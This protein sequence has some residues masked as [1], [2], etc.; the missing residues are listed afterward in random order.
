M[1]ELKMIDSDNFW[2]S[3]KFFSKVFLVGG[4]LVIV[5][6]VF[7]YV[8]PLAATAG[9][10]TLSEFVGSG[11]CTPTENLHNKI[12]F[13]NTKLRNLSSELSS[14]CEKCLNDLTES[15]LEILLKPIG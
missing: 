6:S 8:L 3:L 11:E 15:S 10:K 4:S 14:E 13:I 9:K 12:E 5:S 7:P 2:E 1:E